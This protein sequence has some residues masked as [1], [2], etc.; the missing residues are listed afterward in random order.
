MEGAVT[1]GGFG[2]GERVPTGGPALRPLGVGETLDTA[3]KLYRNN[4]VT[5]WKIVALII[6]P[7]EVLDVIVR[8]VTLPSDVFL[9]DGQLYT[10]SGSGTGAGA[11][12]ALILIAVLGVLAALLST[13]AVFKLVLD[14][15]LGRSTDW[16]ESIAFARHRLASL[17]WLGILS[18]F[19]IVV[20]FILIIVPGI[21]LMV[22]S[23]VAV[24]ALMLEGLTG[25]S[26][27]KRSLDLVD[28]R[29]WATFGR[30]VAA[31]LLY[32]VVAIVI[33]LIA[34]AIASGI[35]ITNVTLY[36][37][38]AGAL[39]AVG[40]I[41]ATP[42]IAAVIAVIYV[43]LR[44]RKEGFDLELLAAGF[45]GPGSTIPAGSLAP[46]STPLQPLDTAPPAG[47]STAPPEPTW[48]PAG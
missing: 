27:L 17:V 45:H 20:G 6:V 48:P 3:I 33:G 18:T 24:P 1:E 16:R 39:T 44:V 9:I 8:R 2:T 38:L 26:A 11:T 35:S 30:L 22:A 37:A 21:W 4:A 13:G 12:V 46:T 7:L 29:W 40:N 14:S 19:L 36:L 10:H 31:L 15:Y 42:F 41:L 32:V 34:G 43:D 5:L 25:F 23:S 47:P 28:G